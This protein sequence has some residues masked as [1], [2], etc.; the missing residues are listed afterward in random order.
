LEILN[1]ARGLLREYMPSW[2]PESLRE[3]VGAPPDS[4]H[5]GER[6]APARIASPSLHRLQS[7]G[8]RKDRTI[9]RIATSP[10]RSAKT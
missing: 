8:Q 3:A 7:E 10:A 5:L 9:D 2:A 1:N 6:V 4:V